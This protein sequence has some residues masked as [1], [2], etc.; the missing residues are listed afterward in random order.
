[1]RITTAL[2]L[3]LLPLSSAV[4][5]EPPSSFS[6]AKKL[7]VNI[8]QDNPSSFYCGCDIHWQGK[9]GVPDLTS[10]GYQVRKQQ[11]RASRIEWE[12]IVPAWQ[13]GHQRQCWQ[14]GGRKLCSRQDSTFRLMEADLHNLVPAIGEVNGDRSNY[15]FTQWNGPQGVSYGRCDMQVDFK[16]RK[17]MP[18][19]RARGSIARS[20]LYMS[21]QYGFKLSKSQRNLMLVWHKQYPVDSWECRRDERISAIQGNHNPYVQQACRQ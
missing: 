5:A 3:L 20:Y 12:H 21:Q 11:K 4:W 16:Q 7:A 15:N 6:K 1:M 14:Q 9:K 8:Y 19:D 2:L 13:F 18:P 10:C 17:V